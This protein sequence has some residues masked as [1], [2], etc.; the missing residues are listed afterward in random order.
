MPTRLSEVGRGF[1]FAKDESI[2]R[3][4]SQLI[5]HVPERFQPGRDLV[6]EIVGHVVH[7]RLSLGTTDGAPK[8]SRFPFE[9]H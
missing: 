5:F 9:D 7:L 1:I 8:G 6:E 3:G 2:T 4:A